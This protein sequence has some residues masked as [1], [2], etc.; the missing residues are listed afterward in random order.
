MEQLWSS[1]KDEVVVVIKGSHSI[2]DWL[3]TFALWTTSCQ[4][5]GL[6]YRVHAGFYHLIFQESQPSCNEDKLGQTVVERLETTLISLL[7]QHKRISITDHSSG[8]SIGYVL[9][10]YLDQK[11]PGCIKRI[12]TFG[13]PA[14]GD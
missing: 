11:N 3:L 6:N 8:G 7:E 14:V 13:Q 10:D 12:L 9:A 5:I 4:R 2:S 1:D